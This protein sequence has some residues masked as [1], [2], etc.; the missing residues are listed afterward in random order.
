LHAEVGALETA[1]GD[2]ADTEDL[3]ARCQALNAGLLGLVQRL[4]DVLLPASRLQ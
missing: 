2:G 3:A 4:S 1:L